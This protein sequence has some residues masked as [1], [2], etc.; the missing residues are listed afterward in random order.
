[1]ADNAWIVGVVTG[2][3][4]GLISGYLVWLITTRLPNKKRRTMIR[5]SLAARYALFRREVCQIL[6]QAEDEDSDKFEVGPS[7]KEL[8]HHE[9]FYSYYTVENTRHWYAAINGLHANRQYVRKLSDCMMAFRAEL[10][11]V[12]ANVE[13]DDDKLFEHLTWFVVRLRE[14][15]DRMESGCDM[16]NVFMFLLRFMGRWSNMKGKVDDDYV[17]DLINSIK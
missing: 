3:M 15:C 8:S 6:L 13:I 1:M 7:A 12:M 10:L 9:A 11:M 2:L 16:E 17:E 5:K 14:E 4:S